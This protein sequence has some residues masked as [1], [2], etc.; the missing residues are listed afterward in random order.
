MAWL[1]LALVFG[2][3]AGASEITIKN[4]SLGVGTGNLVPGFVAG[5]KAASWLT[6]PCTGNIV[7]AQVFWRSLTGGA[8]QAYEDSL[9]IYRAGSFPDPGTLALT[10]GGPLL[11]DGVINEFRYLDENNSV[12]LIVPVTQGETFVLALTFAEAPDPAEGPSVV[13]DMDG[14]TP[15]PSTRRSRQGLSSGMRGKRWV[16]AA[17]GCC[18]PSSTARRSRTTQMSPSR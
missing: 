1:G 14:I 9:E 6:S 17:T 18:A 7:A 10:V 5:E 11:T 3:H 4:D 8:A 12:P 13:E 16:S 15:M 2:G